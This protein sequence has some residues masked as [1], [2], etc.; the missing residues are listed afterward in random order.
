[1]GKLCIISNTPSLLLLKNVILI[2]HICHF[3][4]KMLLSVTTGNVAFI[5]H[6]KKGVRLSVLGRG[7]IYAMASPLRGSHWHDSAPRGLR[8][9]PHPR[10]QS[11]RGWAGW[12]GGVAGACGVGGHPLRGCWLVGL[13]P[14]PGA[15]GAGRFHNIPAWRVP[16][17][18]CRLCINEAKS[19]INDRFMQLLWFQCL[20]LP[21]VVDNYS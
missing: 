5:C 11:L 4:K 19:C 17:W 7:G 10:G 8:P 16:R 1:M 20:R 6:I 9:R 13:V 12:A 2:R 3:Q 18:A 21:H 15:S 14:S